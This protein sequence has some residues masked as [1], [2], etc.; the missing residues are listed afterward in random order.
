MGF[1]LLADL[2]ALFP[3]FSSP[4]IFCPGVPI[5]L[6]SAIHWPLFFIHPSIHAFIH[7]NLSFPLCLCFFFNFFPSFFFLLPL[8]RFCA[9]KEVWCK[10]PSFISSSIGTTTP[11]FVPN[12]AM[13]VVIA[14]CIPAPPISVF[15][16][17]PALGICCDLVMGLGTTH[18][19][20]LWVPS[21]GYLLWFGDGFAHHPS[22]FSLS[23]SL[24]CLLWL[25]DGFGQHPSRFSSIPSL[26]QT[27]VFVVIGDGFWVQPISVFLG[28]L[29]APSFNR[30]PLLSTRNE[31]HST[32]KHYSIHHAQKIKNKT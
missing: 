5:L 3:G 27:W 24:G 18:L 22:L 6:I 9:G 28:L 14:R 23:P 21:L 17:S 20:F 1:V 4:F 2:L 13:G 8:L 30:N 15:F 7:T 29:V 26:C 16:E 25:G 32:V 19:C 31:V 11:S 10:P 12:K